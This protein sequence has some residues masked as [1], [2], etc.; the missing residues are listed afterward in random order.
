[1]TKLTRPLS[2]RM[3][4]G[5]CAGLGRAMGVDPT[6]IRLLWVILSVTM[7]GIGGALIYVLAWIIIPEEGSVY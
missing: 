2:G 6:I 1:M 7:A 5:V 3:I 4:A